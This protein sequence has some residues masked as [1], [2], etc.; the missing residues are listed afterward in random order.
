[1]GQVGGGR[2]G[3]AAFEPPHRTSRGCISTRASS[4]KSADYTLVMVVRSPAK[5]RASLTIGARVDS[6]AP[7]TSA[8]QVSRPRG[9]YPTPHPAWRKPIMTGKIGSK[10]S[11]RVV[12]YGST[13]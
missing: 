9:D 2:E 11:M 1:M 12:A 10:Q 4:I 6:R 3:G 7:T 8:Q 13:V 5:S